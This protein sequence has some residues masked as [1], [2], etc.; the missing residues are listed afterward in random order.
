MMNVPGFAAEYSIASR[1]QF[2]GSRSRHGGLKAGIFPARPPSATEVAC[3]NMCP[4]GDKG[5]FDQC[6]GALG[7]TPTHP[8]PGD[9]RCLVGCGSCQQ[10]QYP[11]G[12]YRACVNSYC[13]VHYIAC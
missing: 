5:C 12:R 1:Q 4:V 10:Y 9:I 7:Q 2:A 13:Q 6:V 8:D 11:R 3:N